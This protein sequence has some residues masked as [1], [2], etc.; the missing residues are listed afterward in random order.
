MF[1]TCE[2]CGASLD[3]GERCDCREEEEQKH[4]KVEMLYRTSRD[5]QVTMIFGGLRYADSD[6]RY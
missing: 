1:R 6:G 2:Y 3:P 5:G 4:Q